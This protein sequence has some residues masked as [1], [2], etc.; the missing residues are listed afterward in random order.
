MR[1]CLA[2]CRNC[3]GAGRL[4]PSAP[5]RSGSAMRGFC[6]AGSRRQRADRVKARGDRAIWGGIMST[7]REL[8]VLSFVA[9]GAFAVISALAQEG[10]GGAPRARTPSASPEARKFLA[11]PDQVVAIRAAR[12]FD[13]R[14]GKLVPNA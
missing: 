10:E 3:S 6:R 5:G 11:P 9:A 2:M 14:S 4:T 12:M 1:H 13:S 7:P 8:V